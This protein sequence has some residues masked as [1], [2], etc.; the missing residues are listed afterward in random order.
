MIIIPTPAMLKDG[1]HL[2][3]NELYKTNP[4]G[5]NC[6][7]S[8]IPISQTSGRYILVTDLVTGHNGLPF[9]SVHTST[10]DLDELA[11]IADQVK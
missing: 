5:V 8:V 4:H 6:T 2:S 1:W 9:Y 11:K 3:G 7:I 10:L